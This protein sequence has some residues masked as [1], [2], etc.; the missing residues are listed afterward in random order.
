MPLNPGGHRS[1]AERRAYW[2]HNRRVVAGLLLVWAA[3]SFGLTYFARDLNFP[4]FGW[5]F[6]FWVAAQGA[7]IVYGL[8][9]GFY[10]WH[11]GRL[12]AAAGEREGDAYRERDAGGEV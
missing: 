7:L 6:S 1:T 8:I 9:V 5:P 3:V 10:A 12:D 11:M 4:F 2:R